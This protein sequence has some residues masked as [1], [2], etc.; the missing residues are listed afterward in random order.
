MKLTDCSDAWLREVFDH[1]DDNGDNQL[2]L[3]RLSNG[4]MG[5]YFFRQNAAC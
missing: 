4:S 3:V 5:A 2:S 1:A